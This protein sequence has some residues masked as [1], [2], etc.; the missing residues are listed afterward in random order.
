MPPTH[1]KPHFSILATSFAGGPP[2]RR[3]AIIVFGLWFLLF[4]AALF[5]PPLL[6]DADAT[7]A[8]A[9]RAMATTG[10]LVTLR[11]NGI[12]YL[13]KAPLPYWL[14]AASFKIF[15][16]NTFAAHLPQALAV[17]LLALLGYRWANQAFGSRTG[18]Y[19]AL[20]VLTST[21]VFLFTRILIPE[22]LLSLTLGAA[23][24]AFLKCLGRI[25]PESTAPNALEK[26]SVAWYAGP[27]FYPYVMWASLALAVLSKGL[28]ALVFFF[29]TAIAFLT[30]TADWSKWRKLRPATGL[31]LFLAIAAPWHILAGLRNQGGADGHG[32]WWFY[33]WNEHVLR[34]LGRRIPRDYNK[35]PGWLYW[36]SHLLWLFPWT[37][38]L[39]LGITALWRRTQHQELLTKQASATPGAPS[40]PASPERM[41]YRAHGSTAVLNPVAN[42]GA[43][44]L[45]SETSAGQAQNPVGILPRLHL[46]LGVTMMATIYPIIKITGIDPISIL[47]LEGVAGLVILFATQRRR[48]GLTPSPFHRIDPQ[49][50][51]ILLLSLFSAIV[52]LFFSLSTNQEYYT[53]PAYLP[54]LLL[55]AATIT[56]AEQ[57]Y[58]TNPS[59][60]R[61]V[62]FAHAAFMFLG[63]AGSLA[64]IYG[65]I[66]SAHL[67]YNP[68]LGTVLAHRGVGSY[69]LATSHLFDLTTAA[70]AGLRFPAVL[71]ALAL[72]F[73]PA[74]A[75]ALRAQRRHLA[76]TTFIAF[77]AAAFLVA[78]H[79]AFARFAPILS[80]Q[81]FIPAI[82]R[83]VP[84]MPLAIY[85]DQ[86]FGSSIPFYLGRPVFLVDG[87][88]TSMLFGSGFPE[89]AATRTFLTAA[90]LQRA[91]TNP[92]RL[93][94]FVPA[95]RRE[96]VLRLLPPN[97]II[98]K[99]ESGK[100]LLIN[101]DPT[102]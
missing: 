36:S 66:A 79:L 65:L 52:L 53:F 83:Y 78:A 96:E 34:F 94:L 63:L 7:H 102:P 44:G 23:L 39:P 38:F 54:L 98:L 50:R 17:L 73:G 30:L 8:Q 29:A 2:P 76:A 67:P 15:G 55:I 71:A 95:E 51:T 25:S 12:R 61:W 21:G 1:T 82:E 22:V 60:V 72:L 48:A 93:L 81:S 99:E 90:D 89:D 31:L 32:F 40:F 100:L 18:F 13:E 86:A 43:P 91:W 26:P 6:D 19:T 46:L 3:T 101:H 68:D 47:L 28:V 11:V 49:Q 37:L 9:A 70:F 84:E 14:A 24:F 58:S 69:T 4:F 45:T 5:T 42:P 74:A 80:S 57:T 87:R 10:D 64:L 77:T 33:F 27:L 62:T 41:G 16:F 59:A 75:W 92:H 20:G 35:M 88:S 56:R 85:G 97:P